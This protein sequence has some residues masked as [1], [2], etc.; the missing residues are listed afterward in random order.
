M[1]R[2]RQNSLDPNAVEDSSSLKVRELFAVATAII[3][4]VA[5]ISFWFW[6]GFPWDNHNESFLWEVDLAQ[7]RFT[8]LFTSNPV[9][10]VINYRP[11][12]LLVAWSTF[13][14]TSGE[15]WL[16]QIVN[17]V[18][19][20]LSWAIAC[21]ASTNR[22]VFAVLSFVCGA[23]FFSGYIYLYHL[24]G[25]FYPPLFL[26]VS[27]LLFYQRQTVSLDWKPALLGLAAAA[28]TALFHPFA[29]L[30]FVAYVVGVWLQCIKAGRPVRPAAAVF[31]IVVSL[32][33]AFLLVGRSSVMGMDDPIDGFIWS[34]RMLT[35]NS[36]A[37]AVGLFLAAIAGLSIGSSVKTRIAC[38]GVALFA[39]IIL[40][41][42]GVP[43]VVSLVLISLGAA[44]F[45]GRIALASLI[46]ACAVLPLA[47]G[48][49][50]PTYAI[51]VLMP[52]MVAIADGFKP[53]P[54]GRALQGFNLLVIVSTV[55]A[56][57]ALQAGTNFPAARRLITPLMA[58]R[59]RTQQMKSVFNWLEANPEVS[60]ELTLCNPGTAPSSQPDSSIDRRYRAPLD[61]LSFRYYVRSHF[62]QRLMNGQPL[63]VCFGGQNMPGT[64]ALWVV[65]GEWAGPASVQSPVRRSG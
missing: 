26:F 13:K 20:V 8:D 52:C 28:V 25:V 27:L 65:N 24:H 22:Q 23:V 46:A 31:C 10:S 2:N 16:Q 63:Y 21:L 48:S 54:V 58:E 59:E 36:I 41:W 43:V 1:V 61:I 47:T 14:L 49:G 42:A 11:L 9:H 51:F 6:L 37:T 18:I 64:K 56:F 19:T 40:S 45:E 15:I 35:V 44:L 7:A 57:V 60:G 29:L 55:V 32:A 39:T 34:Y 5:S 62:G 38:A 53:M 50:S 30:I 17:F 12:G 33:V 3:L 4:S